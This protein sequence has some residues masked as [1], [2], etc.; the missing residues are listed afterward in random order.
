M[1]NPV[2][3]SATTV[4]RTLRRDWRALVAAG[5]RFF[6]RLHSAAAG[7]ARGFCRC[8]TMAIALRMGRFLGLVLLPLAV[9]IITVSVRP[10]VPPELRT[11]WPILGGVPT[12][13]AFAFV[14]ITSY[15]W[16]RS[17]ITAVFATMAA[18]G[19]T[20]VGL[21]ALLLWALSSTWG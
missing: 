13:A 20:L 6:S 8:S 2:V 4:V 19:A 10:L 3:R 14:A 11:A 5:A 7:A 12:V 1:Q 9:L 17:R 21:Y 16:T 18:V 15:G